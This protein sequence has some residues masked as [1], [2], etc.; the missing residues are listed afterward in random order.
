VPD[1]EILEQLLGLLLRHVLLGHPRPH[2]PIDEIGVGKKH[3]KA[4]T[5]SPYIMARL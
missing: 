3:R 4:Y 1:V 5:D 2:G